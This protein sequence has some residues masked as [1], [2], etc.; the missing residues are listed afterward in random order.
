ML[1]EA[2]AT[3][4][5]LRI[6]SPPYRWPC[7]YGMD[8]G[9]RGELLAANLELHEIEDYLGV[10][11]LAYLTMDRLLAATGAPGAGFCTACLTGEYP[12]EVP[13]SLS[14][15]VLETAPAGAPQP[16]LSP[17]TLIGDD[18]AVAAEG[19]TGRPLA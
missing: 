8:T 5:H 15:G 2:G 4:V 7:F 12:I 18:V 3:E 19:P 1:R 16:T 11:S 14:K 10:D 17:L 13:L 9:V 6:S